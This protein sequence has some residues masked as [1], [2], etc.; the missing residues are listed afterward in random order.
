M[1][2]GK[3]FPG[4]TDHGGGPL[5]KQGNRTDSVYNIYGHN[6]WAQPKVLRRSALLALGSSLLFADD[7]V[8]LASSMLNLHC[9]LQ[10]TGVKH[11]PRGAPAVLKVN[12]HC[13]R[14]EKCVVLVSCSLLIT[15]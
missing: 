15:E 13:S 10:Q 14:L 9:G 7:V 3:S 2:T 11:T 8:L 6:F 5:F 1:D 12:G 4:L